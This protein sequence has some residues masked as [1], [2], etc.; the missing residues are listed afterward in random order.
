MP[1]YLSPNDNAPL[2]FFGELWSTNHMRHLRFVIVAIQLSLVTCYCQTKIELHDISPRTRPVQVSGIVSLS[3]DASNSIRT[4]QVEGHFHNVASKDVA[5]LILRFVSNGTS[6]PTLNFTYQKEYFFNLNVL[7][8][9]SSEDFHSAMVRLK[10]APVSQPVQE[11]RVE[12]S[13]VPAASA[14]TVFVQFVDGSTWGDSESAQ[15]AFNERRETLREL[16]RLER[17]LQNGG[18]QMLKEELSKQDSNPPCINSL[19]SECSGKADS[20]MADGLRSMIEAARRHEHDIEVKSSA[21]LDDR[22]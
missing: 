5:L 17:V 20:C 10:F 14:E 11:S 9:G 22:Q 2:D 6:G 21:L 12:G 18:E 4:Y 15:D 16:S 7:G 3:D 1:R 8:K 13:A 19:V